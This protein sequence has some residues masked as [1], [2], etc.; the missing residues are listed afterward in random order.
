MSSSDK[1]LN[2][3]TSAA[4]QRQDEPANRVNPHPSDAP[5]KPLDATTSPQAVAEQFYPRIEGYRITGVLGQ[6]GMGIVYRAVQ[7]KL[8][9]A[10]ALKVLP[11]MI[12][13]ASPNAVARFRREATAAARLH[14]TNIVPIYDFGES[15]DA[16]YYAME[17]IEGKP[18][19]DLIPL[20][21]GTRISTA[22]P[23]KVQ[24]IIQQATTGAEPQHIRPDSISGTKLDVAVGSS[25]TGRGRA[26]YQQVARWVADAAEALNFAHSEGIVHRDIK[27][28]NLILSTDGRIMI[29]D[30]GLAKSEDEMTVTATGALLGTVRYLSPEQAMTK[31]VPVD[32]RTD[33]YS[34]G[35]TLYELLCFQPAVPGTDEKQILSAIMFQEPTAPRKLH[36]YVPE[37]LETICLK[38]LEKSPNERYPTARALADDLRRYL[39][40]IPIVA[41]RPGLLQRARKFA[42]R[43]KALTTGAVAGVLLAGSVLTVIAV[44]RARQ[45]ETIAR[46]LSDGQVFEG[47][48]DWK[49]AE[50]VYREALRASPNH[51]AVLGNL[52]RTLQEVYD[53]TPGGGDIRLVDE[54][55]RYCKEA[56]RL[57]SDVPHLANVYGVLLSMAG[58]HDEA[59]KVFHDETQKAPGSAVLW[60]NVAGVKFLQG[61]FAAAKVHLRRTYEKPEC[62]EPICCHGRRQMAMLEFFLAEPSAARTIDEAIECGVGRH[63]FFHL[64]RARIRLASGDPAVVALAESDARVADGFAGEADPY[65]KRYLALALL[66]KGDPEAALQEARKAKELGDTPP[67]ADLI[68]AAAHSRMGNAGEAKAALQAAEAVWPEELRTP[69]AKLPSRY[70]GMLWFEW[71]AELEEVAR[72]ASA[73]S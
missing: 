67:L 8:N 14:H 68:M 7:T 53:R 62:K 38:S 24:E 4:A 63:P 57:G 5:P 21:S 60:L 36:R 39:N 6:G 37:E 17:L 70:Q 30:F 42:K 27:P 49:G 28:A 18:I 12:G 45:V 19:N 41:R 15:R 69:D 40:D 66:R 16:Y 72:L 46:H 58:R 54:A 1:K 47:R 29:A 11:A 13:K 48:N 56:M 71:G 59:L 61:D 25:S 65:V 55:I 2:G 34:L 3:A 51:P 22:T 20:F 50:R 10:V 33:I 43:N 52:A 44:N 35:A 23:A 9:R 73:S 26:Y 31:R 64:V 32:H